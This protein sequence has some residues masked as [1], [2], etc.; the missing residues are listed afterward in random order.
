MKSNGKIGENLFKSTKSVIL[1]AVLCTV[2]WGSAFPGVK[3]SYRYFHIESGDVSTTM[4]LA[5]ARFFLAGVIALVVYFI[6][7]KRIILPQKA[8]IKGIILT[9]I[10]QTGLQYFFFYIALSH[11]SG[12]KGA[13]LATTITFFSVFLAHIMFQNDKVNVRKIMG[14]IVG[15]AGIIIINLKN[16][17]NLGKFS[18][19][20]DVFMLLSTF[21]AALGAMISKIVARKINPVLVTGYQMMLGG[22]MLA[23]VGGASGGELSTDSINGVVL[24]IY[25]A[26]VSAI[27]FSIWTTLLKYNKP[28]NITI[29]NFAI[30]IFGTSLS[31]IF[32]HESIGG[33]QNIAAL[34]CVCLGIY[35]V[36]KK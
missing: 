32:L 19:L 23:I 27:A 13:I 11:L 31:A 22:A 2:L 4:L 18:V 16:G 14:C 6:Y 33:I 1:L 5:G 3:M 17:G 26:F 34:I 30:P 7:S 36:N 20:G 12:A 25:L 10:I 35:I 24:L 15:F 28:S 29:F 21:S 8:D 9:G